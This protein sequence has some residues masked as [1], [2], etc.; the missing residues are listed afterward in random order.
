MGAGFGVGSGTV[1]PLAA[2]LGAGRDVRAEVRSRAVPRGGGP[3]DL[4]A[5]VLPRVI[6]EPDLDPFGAAQ[7]LQVFDR[8]GFDDSFA[9]VLRAESSDLVQRDGLVSAVVELGDVELRDQM[10]GAGWRYLRRSRCVTVRHVGIVDL[11]LCRHL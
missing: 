3:L 8:L 1:W 11:D 7:D 4:G 5:G 10:V 2:N 9:P 6:N